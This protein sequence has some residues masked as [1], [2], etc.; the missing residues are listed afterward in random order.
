VPAPIQNPKSKIQNR[1][2]SPNLIAL[3]AI[4]IGLALGFGWLLFDDDLPRLDKLELLAIAQ[5]PRRGSAPVPA[6][7]EPNPKSKIQNPKS[8]PKSLKITLNV[9]KPEHIKVKPGDE[10]AKG[11]IIADRPEERAAL[12]A[13]KT[14]LEIAIKQATLGLAATPPPAPDFQAQE[15]ALRQSKAMIESQTLSPGFQFIDRQ[16]QE[17]FEPE[18]TAQ[19]NQAKQ[20]KLEKAAD[21][22]A[23]LAKLQEAKAQY[24][25]QLGQYQQQRERQQ[26]ELNSL[27]V[28]LAEVEVELGQVS[29]VRSP[30]S[31]TVKKAK[32]K[33]Q[34][35]NLMEVEVTIV[36]RAE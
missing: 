16:L 28:Q 10:V 8:I 11:Q 29:A 18:K 20:R 30:Y 1:R 14:Q 15:E 4:S 32:V 23:S 19:E 3:A 17:I 9:A 13:K 6:Q 24:Q 34:T 2:K 21:I 26:Y 25:Q 27:Q 5:E 7:A 31:G 33:G 35:G 36:P 22:E 12:L